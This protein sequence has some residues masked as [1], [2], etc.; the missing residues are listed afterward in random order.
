[1]V[2]ATDLQDAAGLHVELPRSLLAVS[3]VLVGWPIG[4]RFTRDVLSPAVHAL[5]RVLGSTR[6][7]IAA[8]RASLS[9]RLKTSSCAR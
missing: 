1:M 6:V 3:Y 4:L 2:L 9:T 5:P 8:F 7:P